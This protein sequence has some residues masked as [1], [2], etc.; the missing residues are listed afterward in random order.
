[1]GKRTVIGRF[2]GAPDETLR[3]IGMVIVMAAQLDYQRMRILDITA[4]IPVAD[5]ANFT[6]AQLTKRLKES[7]SSPPL[8]RLQ[9]RLNTWIQEVIDLWDIR[10][11]L[12]HSDAYFETRGDGQQGHF[13]LRPKTG[14]V[15]PAFTPQKLEEIIDRLSDAG[16]DATRLE[17]EAGI[18]LHQGVDAHEAH[19]KAH[20]EYEA[21][22]AKMMEEVGG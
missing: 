2:V 18:L 7:V 11:T 8:D 19:L 4:G 1:M 13:M 9:A 6:R 10:D 17:I 16:R 22:V 12:A 20:E 21:R 15:R 3:A 14:K 5:S